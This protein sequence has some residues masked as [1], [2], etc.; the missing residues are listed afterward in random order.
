MCRL[1]A[2]TT[3]INRS[4]PIMK[5]ISVVE[6]RTSILLHF[7]QITWNDFATVD[8]IYMVFYVRRSY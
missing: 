4:A 7:V 3:G 1:L 8:T 2:Q 5:T 6:R